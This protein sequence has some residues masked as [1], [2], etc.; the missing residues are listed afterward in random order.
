MWE[1][2][3]CFHLLFSHRLLNKVDRKHFCLKGGCNLRF[4]FQSI[5]Y[6]EDI[7][8]DVQTTSVETLKKNV[9][10]ILND[11]AFRSILKNSRNL[12]IAEW[13]AP[14]QTGTTQRWKVSLRLGAQ[15]MLIPTKIE[16]SRRSTAIEGGEI[17]QVN[18]EIISAYK[19]QPI[20][21]Q[22]YNLHRA[23][24]QKIGALVNRTETQARDVIDLNILIG[25][26]KGPA[27]IPLSGEI[28]T[29]A[30]ETLMSVSFDDYKS[31]AWPYLIAD[32]QEHYGKKETWNHIQGE[33]VSFIE[34][35]PEETK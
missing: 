33:V 23:I 27:K 7:D 19:L 3:E 1:A 4:Y 35:Q 32:Y 30:A 12:E 11:K 34:K 10:N 5:R 26:L 18:S 31:Q 13:S 16:F 8:F 6:S 15:I 20:L 22:H 21:M 17:A 24:E 2:I 29:R 14:K 28:K 25:L 9:Q